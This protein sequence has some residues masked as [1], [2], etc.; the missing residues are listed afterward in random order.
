MKKKKPT[1]LNM[2]SNQVELTD[3]NLLAGTVNSSGIL[4][5]TFSPTADELA[6]LREIINEIP[7]ENESSDFNIV[8]SRQGFNYLNP[9]SSEV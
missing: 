6:W 8:A 2:T 3:L 1:N 4:P 9:S 5:S 7:S